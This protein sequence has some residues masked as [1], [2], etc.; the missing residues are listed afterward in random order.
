[1]LMDL[2]P[3]SRVPIV[4]QIVSQIIFG[5]ASDGLMP[6]TLIP[7][8]RDLAKQILIHPNT[9]AKAYQ[10]LEELGVVTP[11]RGVGMEVTADAL[12]VCRDLRQERIRGQL[13]DALRAAVSSALPENTIREL[14]EEELNQVNGKSHPRGTRS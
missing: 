7:S 9:V 10:K 12:R 2:D 6:G 11:K 4:E 14:V 13:R 1:M 8:V 5:I 3:D